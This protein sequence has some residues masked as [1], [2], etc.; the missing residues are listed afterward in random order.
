LQRREVV[1]VFR[2]REENDQG[3]WKQESDRHQ[4][5]VDRLIHDQKM[6]RVIYLPRFSVG[7][8]HQNPRGNGTLLGYESHN[9][10]GR[11]FSSQG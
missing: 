6:M 11:A 3:H 9:F 1:D 10:L 8:F 4:R 5:S 7:E 2:Y